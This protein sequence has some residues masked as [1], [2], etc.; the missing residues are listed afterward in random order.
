[1]R[2]LTQLSV[3]ICF[4]LIFLVGCY[5]ELNNLKFPE[6]IEWSPELALPL[7]NSSFTLADLI[8]EADSSIEYEETDGVMVILLEDDSLFSSSA[9]D[10]YSLSDKNFPTLPLVLTTGEI[11]DFNTNGQVTVNRQAEI[12]YDSNLDSVQIESGQIN[13]NLEENFPADGDL[14]LSVSA[15]NVNL[16][17]YQYNWSYDGVNQIT[18]DADSDQF[19]EVTFVIAS[20]SPT[21]LVVDYSLTLTKANNT[22]LVAFENTIDLDLSFVNTEFKGLYG[23]LSTQDISTERNTIKTD[24]LNDIDDLEDVEYYFERPRFSV[25]YINSMGLPVLFD[26]VDF[27][28]YKNGNTNQIN[29]NSSVELAPG[30]FNTP[31]ESSLNLDEQFKS[32]INDRPDSVTLAV[33]GIIDPNDTPDNFVTSESNIQVGY[34]LELP[35]ELTLSGLNIEESFGVDDLEPGNMRYAILN[36]ETAN[37]LPFDVSL[38]AVALS[39]DST[40]LKTLFEDELL[41]AGSLQN[42]STK[43]SFLTLEDDPQTD[44]NELNFLNETARIAIVASL[45]TT[46]SGNEVVQISSQAE[47]Q[48]SLSIQ[49]QYTIDIDTSED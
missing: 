1:M 28:Y 48:F 31:S 10:F 25:T 49:A 22:D 39:E 7:V 12:A 15:A 34:R 20:N 3:A 19:E 45:A 23:D 43:Q 16:L 17:N 32:V 41:T 6:K 44:A 5:S 47:I 37:E 11:N 30:S 8:A 36:F 42:P 9:R 21:M 35:L 33:D 18:T 46:N 29:I 38:K 13:L 27:T 4:L 24:F 40:E 26:V 2:K 14:D